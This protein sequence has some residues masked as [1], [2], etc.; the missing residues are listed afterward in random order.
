MKEIKLPTTV[1]EFHEI[2]ELARDMSY[3]ND[4]IERFRGIK[5]IKEFYSTED[6]PNILYFIAERILKRRWLEAE[7]YIKKDLFC[8]YNYAIFVRK[9]RWLEIEEEL[10]DYDDCWEFYKHHLKF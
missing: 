6:L 9:E 2:R 8:A 7:K 5:D 3:L 10:K 4:K 1:E